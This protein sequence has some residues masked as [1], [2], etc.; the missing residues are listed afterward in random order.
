VGNFTFKDYRKIF[1]A[2]REFDYDVISMRN[3]FEGSYDRSRKVIVNRVDVDV[4]INRIPKILSIWKETGAS[5]TFFLRFHAP[6]YNLFNIG[7]LHITR[8]IVDAGCE[9]GLH[10][11]LEDLKGF[12]GIDPEVVLRQ[13]LALLE[14]LSGTKIVGTASHGDMTDFNN[15]DFW[16]TRSAKD[17]G[18]LYEAY[19]A[20]LWKN[21]R[22]V[23]ESEWTRWKAYDNGELRQDDRRNPM[24][25][26][27]EGAP[28]INLL[29]HPE[30]WY[31]YYVYED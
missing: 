5:G 6:G 13:E 11:E 15:L 27:S 22:Y 1:E 18:L 29:T 10:T 4:K 8:S 19:D 26:M 30:T 9:I 28:V 7:N 20:P 12:L 25:H 24:E 2:A 17:F 23:S 3:F 16:K 21:S 31:D 14:N